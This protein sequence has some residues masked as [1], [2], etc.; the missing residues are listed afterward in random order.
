MLGADVTMLQPVALLVR[1][2]ENVFGF[3]RQG[4]FD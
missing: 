1:V 4:Q 3:R 2:S